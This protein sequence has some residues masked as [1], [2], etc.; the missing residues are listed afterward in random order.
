[1]DDDDDTDFD[2]LVFP[3]R[4]SFFHSPMPHF[5]LEGRPATSRPPRRQRHLSTAVGSLTRSSPRSHIVNDDKQFKLE[6]EI[7]GVKM[8]DIDIGLKDNILTV[9]GHRES[10]SEN[11]SFKSSFSQS[12]SMDPSVEVD[13]LSANLDT[14]VLVVTA[15]KDPKRIKPSIRKIPISGVPALPAVEEGMDTDTKPQAEAEAAKKPTVVTVS[16]PN[17]EAA[18]MKE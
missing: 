5:M 8:E 7:P 11:C 6:V 18:D 16:D 1:M 14:G 4:S 12:Y 2:D 10:T 9:S 13:K 3:P 17:A 15:P